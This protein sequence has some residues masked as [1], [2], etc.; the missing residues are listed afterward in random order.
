[1]ISTFRLPIL[2]LNTP[3]GNCETTPPIEKAANIY[4]KLVTSIALRSA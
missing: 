3:R 2:S 4:D 1:M